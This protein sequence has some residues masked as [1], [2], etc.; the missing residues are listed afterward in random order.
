MTS[1]V[2]ELGIPTP[3]KTLRDLAK[4]VSKFLPLFAEIDPAIGVKELHEL[5]GPIIETADLPELSPG[6][7][8]AASNALC[9]I[10]ECC[11]ASSSEHA[12]KEII[13]DSIW[14]RVFDIYLQRSENAKGKSMRQI[15]L[16]LTSVI[17]K[18]ESPRAL[19]LRRQATTTFLD[20]ICGRQDRLK[21][22]PALQG[23]AHFLLRDVVSISQLLELHERLLARLTE[24]SSPASLQALF[25]AFLAWIVHHDTSLSAGHLIK[26]FLIQARKSLDYLSTTQNDTVSPLWIEPVVSTLQQWPDRMQE[27]KTHVFPYCFLPNVQEYLRFLSYLHFS[28]HVH[29]SGAIPG[30]LRLYEDA[31]HGMEESDE[32]KILIA[33]IEAGKELSLIRDTDSRICNIIKVHDGAIHIPDS[34]FGTWMSHPDPEVRLAGMFLS[35]HSTSITRPM[36]SGT[37]KFLKRNLVHLHTDTDAYFRRDVNGYTQ[38]LFDRL[39]AST[40]TLAKVATK[41]NT[42]CSQRLPIPR[43]CYRYDVSSSRALQ[44]DLLFETLAFIV[45]YIRFL[46]WELRS[47][48]SYQRRITALQSLTIVLRSGLDPGVPTSHLSKSAQGQLNWAHGVQIAN[49]TLTRVLM[50]LILDPFDDIR[51]SA[52][53]VLQLCLLAQ[54]IAGQDVVL[55]TMHRFLERAE[56]MQLRTGRADQ[57][58]GVAR[59]YSLLYSLLDNYPGPKNP[60]NFSS[61]LDLFVHLKQ[62]LRGTLAFA[63]QNLTEAVNGKPVHGTFAALRYIIDQE[64]FYNLM[65]K[66]PIGDFDQWK[67]AHDE[68]LESVADFWNSVQHILCADAPEGLVPDEMEEEA[69]LD[70]KEILSY[71]WRGVKEA[72]VLLRVMIAKAP[73]G[74][75]ERALISPALFERLGQ[76]CFT[77][78]LELRHRGAFSTVSQTFAAFCRRCVSSNIPALRALPETW[79]QGTLLSIQ[80]KAG[81]ITRRSAG[82]P[83]LMASITAADSNKLFPRAMSDLISE[84]ST[85]AQST[86]IEESRLP[87]VH[88]LNCIKEFFTTSRL[89]V[90]S[91]AYMGQG[92]ELAAKTLNS[93]IWPIRNCSLMLFKALIERLLGSSEAQDWKELERARTSRFSYDDYPSLVTILTDLLNPEGPLKQSIE[94]APASGSPLDL[95]GAE[96][97]FPALQI[98]RQAR[99]PETHL[100]V[101]V[102]SV[103]RL[104]AS[105]HWHL[106]D[107]AARTVVSLRPVHQLHDAIFALLSKRTESHNVRHGTLLAVKYIV[108]KLLQSPDALNQ[109]DFSHLMQKLGQLPEEWYISSHCPF[110]R[111][112]FLDVV[113]LCGMALARRPDS[114]L[115]L[116]AWESLTSA[117]S[118]SP[119]YNLGV[120]AAAGDD[121]LRQSL[122]QTFFI[123]RTILRENSLAVMTSEDYQ[124]MDA[125]L[126]LLANKDQDTCCMVLETLDQILKLQPT[127][128]ITIPLDLVLAHVYSVL[129]SARDAEVISKAQDV[130]ANSLTIGTYKTSFFALV[131]EDQV[132]LTLTK[133]EHQCLYGPP[134]N[135]Q[136]GLHLLGFFLDHAYANYPSQ[137][138]SILKAIARYIRILRMTITDT[139]PFDMR[140]AA[141]QSLSALSSIWHADGP[142]I[143]ALSL[144]LHTLLNDDDDEIRTLAARTTSILLH[145][146]SHPNTNH[147]VPLLSSHHLAAFL[148]QKFATSL[149]LVRELSR[150]LIDPSTPFAQELDSARTE[151]TA[152]FAQEKQNLYLDPALDYVLYSRIL[153]HS[154]VPAS[155]YR[156]IQTYTLAAL[157]LLTQTA[158]QEKDG[159]LGW[160]SKPDVFAL[161]VRVIC[162]AEVVLGAEVMVGLRRFA[163]AL[164]A[165]EGHGLLVERVEGVLERG[166]VRMLGDV[167]SSLRRIGEL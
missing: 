90:V 65:S 37:L 117:V 67:Q 61:S 10:I 72:S 70:T 4:N 58:D 88:A 84:A 33:A 76:L 161:V 140:F 136:S 55:G 112:A 167:G 62:T 153:M 97:V 144:I 48:A 116:P 163:D 54:P 132:L 27:F 47:N 2:S 124:G 41:S 18:D 149:T 35:I 107:M 92:L 113:S 32:F 12:R 143:L 148:A 5:V 93:N 131:S 44:Q 118:M 86:N 40:A 122:A 164:E 74:D 152:L 130:L 73:I 69:S 159:A 9:A 78:L 21:V 142:L 123:D 137:R 135:T 134:S 100:D 34:I 11:Q 15:L 101:I 129:L 105:P 6:H 64:S 38:K 3:E 115:A 51:N 24:A 165:G 63:A 29:S 49:P 109:E 82:I 108:R 87:Q 91:E 128:G 79:Y 42:S 162:A 126:V 156:Q 17:T 71:S 68:L 154:N 160:S 46:Q 106:R 26:N 94:S 96:G 158:R 8:A 22:K 56:S 66:A 166:V 19:E 7:R 104:L 80:D 50:D 145:S 45:W 150:R 43:P 75:D 133:L 57:A 39:R 157:A 155:T 102:A 146:Q 14:V 20:I 30:D 125:A 139:N 138:P 52:V 151:N 1:H 89:N 127:N 119:Q 95:H 147:T 60:T 98:L 99:P 36:T 31:R 23:L 85:E 141:A 77:Q 114:I 120:S 110:I 59:A 121:L 53:S 81:A 16:V 28:V 13:D 111:A 25:S 83:A 103:E